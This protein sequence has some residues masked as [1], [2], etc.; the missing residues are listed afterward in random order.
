VPISFTV[1]PT[2]LADADPSNNSMTQLVSYLGTANLDIEVTPASARVTVGATTTVTFAVTNQG[3]QPAPES[4]VLARLLDFDS[5][6]I[7]GVSTLPAVPASSWDPQGLDWSPGTLAVGDSVT[8]RVTVRALAV[9]ANEIR[10][11]AVSDASPYC[12]TSAPCVNE[13]ATLTAVAAKP[14][15]THTPPTRSPTTGQGV[16]AHP[17]PVGQQTLAAT[18]VSAGG[19]QLLAGFAMVLVGALLTFAGWPRTRR[20]RRL[21]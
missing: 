1:T 13:A 5:F 14:S 3:P 2:G 19:Q 12:I 17:T 8:V 6:E 11:A 10:L 21:S 16:T 20:P 9:G 4:Y 18:G 15:A 7:T